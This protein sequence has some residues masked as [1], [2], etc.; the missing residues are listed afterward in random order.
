MTAAPMPI[1]ASYVYCGGDL[2]V[3][4]HF[5]VEAEGNKRGG[6]RHGA[7]MDRRIPAS[8][9][10]DYSKV[11]G[12]SWKMAAATGG[13]REGIPR[14]SKILRVTSGPRMVVRM[15]S[16]PPQTAKAVASLRIAVR[17]SPFEELHFELQ[18]DI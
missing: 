17:H 11:K 14:W 9:G 7:E 12:S 15:R 3:L 8:I 5:F 1:K 16:L 2:P 13:G 18:L 4:P 6:G 10:R